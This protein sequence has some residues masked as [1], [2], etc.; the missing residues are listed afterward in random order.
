MK[1]LA[2]LFSML[3]FL[4]FT[5]IAVAQ[6]EGHFESAPPQAV[7]PWK[8]AG[9]GN[10]YV[11]GPGYFDT[12]QQMTILGIA[13]LRLDIVGCPPINILKKNIVSARA[14][15]Y[16]TDNGLE[17][18]LFMIILDGN[19]E[20]AIFTWRVK[21]GHWH[22]AVRIDGVWKIAESER[23]WV[24]MGRSFT[25]LSVEIFSFAGWINSEHKLVPFQ[26]SL[27]DRLRLPVD[28]SAAWVEMD[29]ATRKWFPM[30]GGDFLLTL[31]RENSPFVSVQYLNPESRTYQYPSRKTLEEVARIVQ[32]W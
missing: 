21:G 18:P 15:R 16:A 13:C 19:E 22:V 1:L 3:V 4:S 8:D 6:E 9:R 24:H 32:G 11:A 17:Q 29:A 31:W 5:G 2:G 27:R 23:F 20:S 7:T 14:S 28:Y 25:N 30:D 12:K 10:L 26:V